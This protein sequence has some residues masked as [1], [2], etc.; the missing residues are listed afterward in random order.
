MKDLWAE[1]VLPYAKSQTVL[2]VPNL[3]GEDKVEGSFELNAIVVVVDN[4]TG[5]ILQQYQESNSYFSDAMYLATFSIDTAPYLLSKGVRAFGI[6]VQFYGRSSNSYSEEMIS[7]FVPEGTT[8]R[9]VLKDEMISTS[10]DELN[11]DCN[12]QS[13]TMH[14]LILFE[15]KTT[16]NYFNLVIKESTS[17][18]VRQKIKGECNKIT[19]KSERKR[20]FR[21][22][23]EKYIE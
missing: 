22:N 15:T 21:Y 3:T 5:K 11:M 20:T 14:A 10:S 18:V 8:L 4:Q 17:K 16:K 13:T 12:G 7:L 6:R 23:G 1:K 2:V 9:R 19:E